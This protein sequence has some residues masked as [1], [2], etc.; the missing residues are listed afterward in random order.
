MV[1]DGALQGF[2]VVADGALRW[3]VVNAV[4]KK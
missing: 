4:P 2:V 3:S 1:D